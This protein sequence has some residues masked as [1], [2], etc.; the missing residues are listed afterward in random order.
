MAEASNYMHL[1]HPLLYGPHCNWR[2][3]LNMD[4]TPVYFSMSSKKMLEVVGASTVFIR[5]LLKDTRRATV[6]VTIAGDGTLLPLTIIFKEKYRCITQT[7]FATYP[8]T[9]HHCCQDAVW[10]DKQVMLT[11]VDKVLALRCHV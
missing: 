4:Q 6:A 1:P 10:M 5:M 3:I 7:E 8:T 9:H 11:W 2:F